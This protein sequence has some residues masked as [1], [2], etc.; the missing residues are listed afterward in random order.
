M[1]TH[2]HPQEAVNPDFGN[3]LHAIAIIGL[4]CV[5]P[6]AADIESFWDLLAQQRCAVRA[7]PPERWDSLKLP[8]SASFHA[9]FINDAD[10]FDPAFFGISPKEAA[11]LDPRQRLILQVAWWTLEDAGIAADSLKERRLGVYIGA[12]NGEFLGNFASPDELEAHIGIGSSN[13]VL[14]NRISHVLGLRGPS[15][16]IDTACSSSLVAVHQACRALQTGDAEMALAGGVSLM[17]RADSSVALGAGNMLAPDGLCKTFDAAA[18]GYG[19]G[20]GAG[21]VLLKRLDQALRD[22]DQIHAVIRGSA[23]NHDGVSNGITA[24]NGLSQEGL[25][26]AALQDANL[27]AAAIQYVEAHGTGTLLGDP[28]ETRALGRALG[29]HERAQ[30]LL[31]GSVKTN[32]GHLEAAAGIAGLIKL[33]LALKHKKIPASLHYRQ[34]NPHINFQQLN[35]NVVASTQDWPAN[36]AAA[37]RLGSVSAFGFGGSNCHL[38]VQEFV[39]DPGSAPELPP[40]ADILVLSAADKDGLIRLVQSTAGQL[41]AAASRQFQALCALSRQGRAQLR[42]RLAVVAEDCHDART[43]LLNYLQ[44]G[45][46]AQ[47]CQ[48][49]A[50]RRPPKLAWICPGQGAQRPGMASGLMHFASFRA[51]LAQA[52]SVLP[53]SLSE[54]L[55]TADPRIDSTAYTQA[56]LLSLGV[57]LA[58]LLSEYGIRPHCLAGHSL[59]EYTAA[60]IAGALSFEQALKLVELRGRLMAGLTTP[61][62][63]LAV[64]CDTSRIQSYLNA[65]VNIAAINGAQSLTLSG[66]RS[67]IAMLS[68]QLQAEGVHVKALRV[69]TAFHSA[70]LEPMLA[71]FA[72]A[73]DE[74]Q[75]Q[76]LQIPVCSNLTG[77]IFAVGHVYDSAYWLAH[78]RQTVQF[79]ANLAALK[80]AGV[81]TT[82]ELGAVPV[83]TGMIADTYPEFGALTCLQAGLADQSAFLHCLASQWAQGGKPLFET[84]RQAEG[85]ALPLYPFAKQSFPLRVGAVSFVSASPTSATQALS[86]PLPDT[87]SRVNTLAESEIRQRLL[88]ILAKL[89][90]IE[91]NKLDA[92]TPLLE[93]GADSLILMQAVVRIENEFAVKIPVRAFFESLTSIDALAVHLF[94]QQAAQDAQ[95]ATVQNSTKAGSNAEQTGHQAYLAKSAPLLA[96][97]NLT[98]AQLQHL[99]EFSQR[100]CQRTAK[101]KQLAQTYRGVLADSRASAGFRFSIKEMLYPIVGQRAQ[102]S[103]VW[104][105]DGNQYIDISMGFGVQLFGHE[106]EFLQTALAES[107]QRGLR[108]GPQSDKAGEV[109]ALL[110]EL[111][112]VERVAFCSSGTEAV[113]TALRLARTYTGRQKIAIFRDSYHGHFDGVLAEANQDP[114]LAMPRVAGIT[115]GTVADLAVFDYGSEAALVTLAQRIDQFAAVLVEPVQSRNP[116]LQP[117]E[118]L[119]RLRELTRNAASLLIFDEVLLG[120]RLHPG[121]A[122]AYF[123]V[124]AD[125]V[126]YG[127]IVGGGLPIGVIAGRA[128]VMAGIDGGEWQYGDESFPAAPTTFFAGTFNK[129]PLVM[130]AAQAVLSE[131]KRQGRALYQQL[132]HNT[133]WLC[134]ELDRL[135]AEF[136]APIRMASCGSLFRFVFS[137]NLDPFFYHLLYRGLYVWE[138]RNLFLSTAHTQDDLAAIVERVAASLSAL[139]QAGFI[140]GKSL[141]RQTRILPLSKAQIQLA[142]LAALSDQGSAAYTLSFALELQ[143]NIKPEQIE[144]CFKQLIARHDALR[145]AID[146]DAGLQKISTEL[147]WQLPRHQLTAEQLDQALQQSLA[148]G[149]DLSQ[150]GAFR[151]KLFELSAQHAVLLFAV[152]HVFCDGQSLQILLDELAC[153]LRAQNLPGQTDYPALAQSMA[154]AGSRQADQAHKRY[155]LEKLK[156]APLGI[157]LPFAR[158]RPALRAF[159]GQRVYR[160]LDLQLLRQLEA[161]AKQFAMSSSMILLAAF[162]AT[163]RRAGAAQDMLIGVPYSGRDA[164]QIPAIN[165]TLGYCAHLLPLRLSIPA[166]ATTENVLKHVKE[167]FLDAL[168]HANYPLSQLVDDLGIIRDPSRPPLLNMSFNVDRLAQLPDLPGLQVRSYN[169]PVTHARFD[170]ACNIVDWQDGAVI[171]LDFDSALFELS[172]MQNLLDQLLAMMARMAQVDQA[173]DERQAL[174]APWQPASLASESNCLLQRFQQS[175]LSDAEGIALRLD[176][177]ASLTRQQLDAW[178]DQ[179]ARQILQ[180]TQACPPE[181][182]VCLLLERDFSMPAAM[183]AAW[184][185]A[186]AFLPLDTSLPSARLIELIELAQAA[187]VLMPAAADDE[188]YERINLSLASSGIPS[189]RVT[190]MPP[191]L[192]SEARLTL[193]VLPQELCAYQLFTSGSTGKP[194]RVAVPHRALRHYLDGLIHALELPQGLNYALV[195][196]FAADLG[197]TAV[198]PALFHRGCLSIVSYQVARDSDAY[199]ALMQENP[200]DLLKIVPSH[201]QA[202]LSEAGREAVL[203]RKY[204]VLGGEAASPQLLQNLA[205][206]D[207]SC[208][209]FNHFGPT[210]AT[211]GVMLGEWQGETSA[212]P[213]SHPIGNNRVYLL[214]AS[215]QDCSIGEVGEIY[216]AGPGLALGYANQAEATNS[217]FIW[218]THA[219][220]KE[221]V[222]KTGDLAV[223]L[224]DGRLQI[225]GRKDDQLKIRGYR[226]EPA[227]IIAALCELTNVATATVILHKSEHEVRPYLLAYVVAADKNQDLDCDQLLDSLRLRLPE[228]M[229]PRAILEIS[230]LPYTANGKLDKAAL[231]QLA[232]EQPDE[233]NSVALDD[234]EQ[235]VMTVWCA[236]LR[237]EKLSKQSNFFQAGG[238]SILA[239]QMLARLRQAG[240]SAKAMDL[241]SAPTL[242]EFS[243]KLQALTA[244]SSASAKTGEACRLL[245]AQLRL[246]QYMQSIPQ[247]YNLSVLLAVADWVSAA[248]LAQAMQHIMMHHDALR[249]RFSDQGGVLSAEFAEAS[250]EITSTDDYAKVQGSLNPAQGKLVAIN[251][252]A[253][254][255]GAPA[256]VLL[257]VHHLVS[258]G[259]SMQILLEDIRQV[260]L[261]LHAGQTPRLAARSTSVQS[262]AEHLHKEAHQTAINN[263]LEYWQICTSMPAPDLPV[264]TETTMP[265]APQENIQASNYGIVA[266]EA[267]VVV[268]LNLSDSQVLLN[269]STGISAEDQIIAALTLTIADWNGEAIAY[270]ELESHGRHSESTEL[271]LSRS[272]GWF[273]QRYPAWFDLTGVEISAAAAEIAAQRKTIPNQ[274]K[275]YSLLRY[276]GSDAAQASLASA[277]MPDISLNYM[278]QISPPPEDVFSL[279]S[280]TPERQDRG[281]ERAGNLPRLHKLALEA[282]IL[283]QQLWLVWQYDTH[284]YS[285]KQ[286]SLL[287]QK[288][289][290]YLQRQLSATPLEHTELGKEEIL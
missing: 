192:Q 90:N 56:A 83:L 95:V 265:G 171:E 108:I 214:D 47:V 21:L 179:L 5:F 260:L 220:Q 207:K 225:L 173:F 188:R 162:A 259:V 112:G 65:D 135:F 129:H 290:L 189:L 288:M 235:L 205:K 77:D 51:T 280:W 22:G 16:S 91:S 124:R 284:T 261:A 114:Y 186:K 79:A 117:R 247:H 227:E 133:A 222:Y 92:N 49:V 103:K 84:R 148:Q 71:E 120:F 29:Q 134:A 81:E 185:C 174:L 206:L 239:I 18:N 243:K 230:A 240:W 283:Q 165:H 93:L 278:G 152:H 34:A 273:T 248:M 232:S 263:Q 160:Q 87:V 226:I 170:L 128:E 35:L 268:K 69:S 161:K 15:M 196:T 9:G 130:V 88:A 33:I 258:D 213:F 182:P 102:G 85:S 23:S 50:A 36:T 80:Q 149:F 31:I 126:T 27:T 245:P 43:R 76:P 166:R 12:V 46:D 24:P 142:T 204:L 255:A 211:V 97:V 184:K 231:P 257:V 253:A 54:L 180:L 40:T 233:H 1:N 72:V 238:D 145:A 191:A 275:A 242:A 110:C 132:E 147:T 144:A 73:L 104:D 203:P 139:Q 94:Q 176:H 236:L 44:Q 37:S 159:A 59:G 187:A 75:W 109:A 74:I 254:K 271:D 86:L 178:S 66:T 89:L 252:L 217:S 249:L 8:A 131:I 150:P 262:W 241:Y 25:I 136:Q 177:Q 48:A 70:L 82:V 32:I 215:G 3:Q 228:Y 4:A 141:S 212:I 223:F 269:P 287:A 137:E 10:C 208:R 250:V 216:L 111:T 246:R 167:V 210:E 113:M 190:A 67:A 163:L 224:A 183:L 96:K 100:Y 2:I 116:A 234:K 60:V 105:V 64:R 19:R 122:Q 272:V 229:L 157:D 264:L 119:H 52:D 270:L 197:L 68:Q 11:A 146:L 155:W 98:P 279:L 99:Q 20:E 282:F 201:L 118:F 244:G 101:S 123:D 153:L 115:P 198:L 30:A 127:K 138:G 199:A 289:L 172:D 168:G 63:M 251:W 276:L 219:N 221:R 45:Y 154:E 42:H 267:Q 277:Q 158:A 164:L 181:A 194:K 53:W 26:T 14:A 175:V 266:D 6:G 151:L 28:T 61:G 107:L 121:G 218:R 285:E 140:N 106:P 57:G 38:V 193:P 274:G 13:A 281:A 143:G 78:T 286:I 41:E 17:L 237:K 125:L 209:I 169:L 62:A 55:Q 195:S 200:V 39:A 202:W 7:V 58:R 156:Q 256:Q